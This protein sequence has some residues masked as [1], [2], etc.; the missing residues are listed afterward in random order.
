MEEHK[1]MA[2]NEINA[3]PEMDILDVPIGEDEPQ[4][5]AKV[6]VIEDVKVEEVVLPKETARKLVL[7]VRHPDMQ[8]L[9]DIN[10]ARYQQRDKLK[11]SGLWY[12]LDKD[13]NL[14]YGSAV[15]H[16][17]RYYDKKTAKE[18][19]GTQI[20]T[21]TAENGYLLVKAY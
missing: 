4:V 6:V 21:V 7:K 5:A 14:S 16:V 12:K 19:K 17:L 10:G 13:N 8:D 2:E 11:S 20:H 9:I 3:K 1:K 18:L 15:A